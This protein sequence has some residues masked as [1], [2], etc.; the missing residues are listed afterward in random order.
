[1]TKRSRTLRYKVLMGIVLLAIMAWTVVWFVVATIVDRHAERA[2]AAARAAGAFAECLNRS[3][4]GFPFRIEVRC[5][6]G[7][8]IGNADAS[9]TVDGL[10]AAALIYK[11]SRLILESQGPLSI[12]ADGM[13]PVSA[14]WSLA[15][16]SARIDI[17]ERALQRIDV[18]V[19]DGTLAVGA[20]PPVPF[21][22]LDLNVRQNP[23]D[24]AALDLAF[25]L[26]N[27]QPSPDI[28]PLSLI[29]QGTLS[30]GAALLAGKPDL[31]LRTLA[32]DGLELTVDSA[33]I[34]TVAV[35][36]SAGGPHFHRPGRPAERHARHRPRRRRRRPAARRFRPAGTEEDDPDPD[37][38]RAGVR[39]ADLDRRA[40][41]PE[42]D[43]H[44][45]QR[46]GDGGLRA[47]VQAPAGLA[48]A[49]L[50]VPARVRLDPGLDPARR[51]DWRAHTSKRIDP[52]RAET[53]AQAV[54]APRPVAP[55]APG[56]PSRVTAVQ[57]PGSM[58]RPKLGAEV[59]CPASMIPI[60]IA[61][62]RAKRS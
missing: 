28:A 11:P 23:Q 61:R 41:G 14:D 44:H 9:I 59:S 26:T 30:E 1:M 25:H 58:G 45:P 7:S 48:R 52:V 57:A 17:D 16:A 4:R 54:R 34:E 55:T 50:A 56:G 35:A 33:G 51:I 15:H 38:Q 60:R 31:T 22:E 46:A 10:T 47:A 12:A 13:P 6:H 36:L 24:E 53:R 27:V 8:R 62:V 39:A 43:A 21:A 29:F 5:A 37:R 19:K 40:Q 42:A 18:E 32:R 49:P 2:E 3:I 20:R